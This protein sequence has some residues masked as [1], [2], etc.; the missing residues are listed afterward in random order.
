MNPAGPG[1]QVF[2][3]TPF[4]L[5]GIGLAGVNGFPRGLVTNDYATL[6]PRVGFSEDLFGNGKTVL[7]GGVGTFY[8]RMQ[9]NDIYNAA[10]TPPFAYNPSASNVYVSTP[11][12]SWVTGT[13]AALPTFASSVTNLPQTYKAPA[14]AQ[15]SLGVQ[16]E[17]SPSIIW[18]VQYVGNLAWHQN[19]ERHINNYPLSFLGT[20][21]TV[22]DPNGNSH[23]VPN[24]ARAG[25]NNCNVD[26][27]LTIPDPKNP[28]KTMDWCSH[29]AFSAPDA[30]RAFAGWGD[31]NQQEN[32]TNGN[33]NGFQTGVRIQNRWGLSGEIDYTYS[34]EIDLTTYD[35]NGV[36]N[37]F[38]LKYDKGS[39]ALDRRNIFSV[40]YVYKLPVFAKST[41][42]LHSTLG[43]WELAGTFIDESG[44]LPQNQGPGLSINYDSI[45][46]D[47]GYT[48]RPNVSGKVKYLKKRGEWF[49]TSAFSKPVPIWDGGPNLGFGSARKDAV[50]GP[51]RVNFTTSLYKSFAMTERAR[52][53]LRFESFNTFNH[54]EA[55]GLNA[56][57]GA[58]QFGQ[59][60]SAQDPRVM[61]LGGKFIF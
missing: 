56:S 39:G 61:E 40:N 58:S 12:K 13:S 51:G 52:V 43:G 16:H 36:S 18:V 34:H 20:T 22:V 23:I 42:L 54:F 25:D 9:G 19:I 45:G 7:R 15:F 44:T 8:E 4:Y 32:T 2:D 6:Q 57:L 60:T 46:L 55:N 37:P 33:Y 49:D 30:Y 5:N 28:G 50:V 14:V 21:S 29:Q 3:G 41:G 59:I 53:E 27:K 48:N 17:L 47:G 1:F 38:N 11:S 35:L 31:I 24:T 26:G 10:T